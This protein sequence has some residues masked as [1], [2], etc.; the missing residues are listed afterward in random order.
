MTKKLTIPITCLFLY[1]NM[2]T[3]AQNSTV[4]VQ[5]TGFELK[6]ST[7]I[8][9]SVF[10]KEDF[11]ETSIQTKSISASGSN[12][13]VEFEL[14]PGE[15]AISTYHDVNNNGTLDRRFY[16]KPKEPY[17]FSQNIKPFGKPSFDKC[18]FSLDGSSK[19]ISIELIN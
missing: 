1:V 16:G 11:L 3:Q 12:V 4:D 15:Y 18:K 2:L 10:S 14:P 9:V 8:F 17:G 13:H 19:K 7:K 6:K 5:V